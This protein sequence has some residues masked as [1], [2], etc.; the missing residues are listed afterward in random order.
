MFNR[1][2]K[3][4][5]MLEIRNSLE[6]REIFDLIL[7]SFFEKNS[8]IHDV[9]VSHLKIMNKFLLF[10]KWLS[11]R[12]EEFSTILWITSKYYETIEV[13][14]MLHQ[15]FF[16]SER[17]KWLLQKKKGKSLTIRWCSKNIFWKSVEKRM[18]WLNQ[19]IRRGFSDNF[20][21][22]FEAHCDI[23]SEKK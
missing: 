1:F 22:F 3:L 20:L 10:R 13:I 18:I 16:Q 2:Q 7:N 5:D 23:N 17:K 19:I 21:N 15:T 11:L 12:L 4:F 8:E 14:K 9:F 6:Q